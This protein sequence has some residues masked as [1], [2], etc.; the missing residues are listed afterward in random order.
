MDLLLV[1]SWPVLD[2]WPFSPSSLSLAVPVL[3]LVVGHQWLA[4]NHVELGE[5]KEHACYSPLSRQSHF[6]L[7]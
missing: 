3:A 2:Y 7:E 4:S 6:S 1:C 5:H